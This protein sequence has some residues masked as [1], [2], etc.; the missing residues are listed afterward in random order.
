MAKRRPVNECWAI[1]DPFKRTVWA[2]SIRR[3]KRAA[4]ATLCDGRPAPWRAYYREG[5]RVMRVRIVPVRVR[6]TTI[7]KKERRG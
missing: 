7:K 4:I 5:W 1:F 2:P 6:V 3:S